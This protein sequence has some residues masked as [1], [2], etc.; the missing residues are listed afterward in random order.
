M[1]SCICRNVLEILWGKFLP[2][3]IAF[4][5]LTLYLLYEEFSNFFFVKPT[6]TSVENEKI[7]PHQKPDIIICPSPGFDSAALRKN[8]YPS[9]FWYSM[10]LIQGDGQGWNGNKGNGAGQVVEEIVKLKMSRKL[11]T[12]TLKLKFENETISVSPRYKFTRLLH[13]FGRCLQIVIPDKAENGTL[14]GFFF[15]QTIPKNGSSEL[16]DYSLYLGDP[17]HR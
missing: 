11:P 6:F 12:S 5:V 3:K 7:K 14:S 2:L 9:S 17:L 8:G 1:V 10:G 4:A 15:K 13:K 16:Y